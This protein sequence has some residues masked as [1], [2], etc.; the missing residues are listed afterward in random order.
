MVLRYHYTEVKVPT[1]LVVD[2]DPALTGLLTLF[3]RDAGYETIAANSGQRALEMVLQQ[4]PDVVLLD[5]MMPIVS[6]STV[7]REIKS[8]EATKHIPVIVISGDG[9]ADTKTA[10]VGADACIV[11]PFELDEVLLNIRKFCGLT[12]MET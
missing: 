2:D 12:A 7:C 4:R 5:L 9:R 10:D 1:V 11:K 3:L 8:N 6:G